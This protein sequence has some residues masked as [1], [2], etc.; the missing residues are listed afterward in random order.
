[1]IELV[2]NMKLVEEI[3]LKEMRINFD[4]IVEVG[5][6]LELQCYLKSILKVKFVQGD[7]LEGVDHY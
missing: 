4:E 5:M 2:M 6:N 3:Q 7:F 1:M